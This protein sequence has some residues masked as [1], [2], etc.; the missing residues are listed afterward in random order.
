MIFFGAIGEYFEIIHTKDQ[1]SIELDNWASEEFFYL[2]W[3]KKDGASLTVN[4]IDYDIEENTLIPLTSYCRF[5]VSRIGEFQLLK[6]NK[7]FLCV[8]NADSEVGCKG[9]LYF[10]SFDLPIIQLPA[11]EINRI[12]LEFDQVVEELKVRDKMQLEMLRM[13]LKRVLIV[14]TRLFKNQKNLNVFAEA[15]V[16]LVREFSFLVEQHY[17]NAHTVADYATMLNKSPKTIS[18]VFKKVTGKSPLSYI[19][20]RIILEAKN[21]LVYSNLEISEVGYELGFNDVQGFSRFFKR[22]AKLSPSGYK[23]NQMD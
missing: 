7:S 8:L 11:T 1:L 13:I 16:D 21:L 6:Y 2:L 19:H 15:K 12:Q 18:N 10:G 4:S 20:D 17:R 3:V 22:Y 9:L 14:C 23:Q 5:S